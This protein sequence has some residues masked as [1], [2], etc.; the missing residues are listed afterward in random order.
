LQEL[1][2]VTSWKVFG[3]WSTLKDTSKFQFHTPSYG[4]KN[5]MAEDVEASTNKKDNHENNSSPFVPTV[6]IGILNAKSLFLGR[7]GSEEKRCREK[8]KKEK[9]AAKEEHHSKIVALL[10]ESKSHLAHISA[11]NEQVKKQNLSVFTLGMT[12]F[13]L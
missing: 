12:V 9:E 10:D 3:A 8:K 4:N 7:K 2:N 5:M 13:A 11:I 6:L 1:S